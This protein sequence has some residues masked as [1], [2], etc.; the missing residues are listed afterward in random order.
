M[1][2]LLVG[3]FMLLWLLQQEQPLA[4]QREWQWWEVEEEEGVLVL[5]THGIWHVP[6][7]FCV[8]VRPH[9]LT[10]ERMHML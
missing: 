7:L 6:K 9:F 8:Y 4:L 1:L 5:L 10:G 2:L 3:F